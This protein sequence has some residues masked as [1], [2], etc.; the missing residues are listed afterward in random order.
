MTAIDLKKIPL[1]HAV[2]GLIFFA[3]L[4]ANFSARQEAA[5]VDRE[6]VALKKQISHSLGQALSLEQ[7][8]KDIQKSMQAWEKKLPPREEDVIS[9][10]TA[11]AKEQRM[12]LLSIH[13][14]PKTVYLGEDN[15]PISVDGKTCYQ[16]VM[17]L[18]LKGNYHQLVNYVEA[19][20][21]KI[22]VVFTIE[23]MQ[24]NKIAAEPG[25]LSIKITF[26]LYLLA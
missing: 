20:E 9:A 21:R 15:L 23:Q 1:A 7:A 6:L 10:V 5:R 14:L 17:S 3:G 26:K 8:L 11:A 19:M 16:V 18:D 22:P 25:R 13:S 4:I 12:D 24:I 2:V